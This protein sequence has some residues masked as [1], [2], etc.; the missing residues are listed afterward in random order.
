MNAVRTTLAVALIML[1]TGC[2][3]L[4]GNYSAKSESPTSRGKAA[5]AH[6]GCAACHTIPGIRGANGLVGPSLDRVA[7]RTYIAGVQTN[8][9]ANMLK[10]IKN[11]PGVDDKTAMPNLRVT[12]SDASDIASYLYTL[13]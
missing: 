7:S 9:R 5:I 8:T 4:S 11:P 2:Q 13:R 3:Q 12:D 10:W 6:Y 1:V